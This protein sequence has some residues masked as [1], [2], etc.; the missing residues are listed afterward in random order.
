MFIYVFDNETEE[1]LVKSGFK[2]AKFSC[3]D[4][5]TAFILDSKINF[6]FSSLD[7]SKFKITNKIKF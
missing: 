2:K 3:G 5:C 4:G 7:K 1:K 6:N